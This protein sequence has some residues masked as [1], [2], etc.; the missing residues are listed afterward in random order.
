MI[1]STAAFI[2]ASCSHRDPSNQPTILLLIKQIVNQ[3]NRQSN[4]SLIKQI[5]TLLRYH[6]FDFFQIGLFRMHLT[7]QTR[8]IRARSRQLQHILLVLVGLG[9]FWGEEEGFS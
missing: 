1:D 5:I 7:Q 2:M 3:T 9:E 6:H 4:K 8:M